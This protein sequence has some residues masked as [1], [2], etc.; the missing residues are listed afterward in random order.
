VIHQCKQPTIELTV[1]NA[2]LAQNCSLVW[3]YDRKGDVGWMI[4]AM[5]STFRKQQV[6]MHERDTA[7]ASPVISI[8]RLMC[9]SFEK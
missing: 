1:L 6:T 7:K 9:A 5:P 2:K 4:K 8:S 3:S